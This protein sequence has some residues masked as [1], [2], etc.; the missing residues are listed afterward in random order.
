MSH[1]NLR[2][3]RATVWAGEGFFWRNVVLVGARFSIPFLVGSFKGGWYVFST[4]WA[5]TMPQTGKQYAQ[6]GV[7]LGRGANRGTRAVVSKMLVYTNGWGEPG[8]SV[9]RWFCNPKGDHSER[10]HILA[11]AFHEQD[12]KPERRFPRTR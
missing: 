7:D 3:R 9:D 10:F 5:G 4:V 2:D 11:H 8:N 1:T 6:V 12:V